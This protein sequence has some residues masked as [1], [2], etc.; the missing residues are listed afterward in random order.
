MFYS[1]DPARDWDNY[2][3]AGEKLAAEADAAIKAVIEDAEGALLT[4]DGM[5]KAIEEAAA[6]GDI[7]CDTLA[8]L[9]L[10]DAGGRWK[11]LKALACDVM[12]GAVVCRMYAKYGALAADCL[13]RAVARAVYEGQA[14]PGIAVPCW[15]DLPK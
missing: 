11:A 14:W 8:A 6:C 5:Q 4:L 15:R 2:C 7:G 3:E 9:M 1:S 12:R 10:G 13:A